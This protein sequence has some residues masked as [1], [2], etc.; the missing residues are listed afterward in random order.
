MAHAGETVT[1]GAPLLT[2]TRLD[3]VHLTL[4]IPTD[5]IGGVTLGRSVEVRVD[6]FPDEIFRGRV[7]YISPRAEF[8]P[9]SLQTPGERARAVFA[10]RVRLPNADGRLKPGVPADAVIE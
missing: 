4:Y 2:L 1:A 5:Q 10:I 6:S 9:H 8:T 7:V 3:P